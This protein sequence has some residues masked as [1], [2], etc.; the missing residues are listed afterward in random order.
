MANL[1]P[2]YSSELGVNL[3]E[4]GVII[5]EIARSSPV[6]RLNVLRPGDI[7]DSVDGEDIRTVDQLEDILDDTGNDVSFAVRRAGRLIEC[8][9]RGRGSYS[10]R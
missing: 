6:R 7:F 5:L 2:A 9:A 8:Q 1:S 10:C 4:K 3:F